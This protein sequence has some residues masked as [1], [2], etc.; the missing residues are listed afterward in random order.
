M[1]TCCFFGLLLAASVFLMGLS[2]TWGFEEVPLV[3]PL[4]ESEFPECLFLRCSDG[5]VR[6]FQVV[7]R[8][9]NCVVLTRKGKT[10]ILGYAKL[11]R[12]QAAR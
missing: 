12:L 5:L 6:L 1:L 4:E 9:S 11:Q 2:S 8:Q 3:E 10:W 7:E